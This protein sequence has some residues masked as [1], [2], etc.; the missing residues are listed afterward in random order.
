MLIKIK[1]KYCRFLTIKW[2]FNY[3]CVEIVLMELMY[4]NYF[5]IIYPKK[6]NEPSFKKT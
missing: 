2:P 5:A 1:K 3:N 4:F 6:I